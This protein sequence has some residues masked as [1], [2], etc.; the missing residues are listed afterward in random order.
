MGT[1]IFSLPD[2]NGR[3]EQKQNA[4]SEARSR[5]NRRRVVVEMSTLSVG[6]VTIPANSSSS[7]FLFDEVPYELPT[8]QLDSLSKGTT[9]DDDDDDYKKRVT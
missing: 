8:E 9:N 1:L 4:I 6:P 2:R 3:E 7:E 5:Y